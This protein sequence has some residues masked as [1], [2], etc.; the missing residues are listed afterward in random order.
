[1]YLY[2]GLL[3]LTVGLGEKAAEILEDSVTPISEALRSRSEAKKLE[4]VYIHSLV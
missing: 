4:S 2:I 1:M 3:A